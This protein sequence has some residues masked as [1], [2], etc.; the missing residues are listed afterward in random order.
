MPDAEW[1]VVHSRE[2][3]GVVMQLVVPIDLF[4]MVRDGQMA[5][6]TAGATV[7]MTRSEPAVNPGLDAA[8]DQ[9][10]PDN[11]ADHSTQQRRA[12]QSRAPE[13]PSY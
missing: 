1:I 8:F 7:L 3:E 5:A 2:Q 6:A 9:H 11:D 13:K 12:L 10:E 4:Q